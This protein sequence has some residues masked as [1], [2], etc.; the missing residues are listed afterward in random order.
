MIFRTIRFRYKNW[1]RHFYK[2]GFVA[3]IAVVIL[4]TGCLVFSLVTLL[5]AT[6][7]AESVYKRE[8]RIQADLNAYACLDLVTV[9]VSKDYFLSGK[10][11]IRQFGCVADIVNDMNGGVSFNVEAKLGTVGANLNRILR[12]EDFVLSVI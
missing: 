9:M 5:G 12:F 11:K 3:T 10:I 4:A 6:S 7:Y 1:P 8:L 2:K